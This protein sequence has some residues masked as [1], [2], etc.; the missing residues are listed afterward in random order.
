[1]ARLV[2]LQGSEPLPESLLLEGSEVVLGRQPDVG[3]RLN[4]RDVSRRHARIVVDGDRYYLEDLG[5]SNG[6]Y[7]NSARIDGRIELHEQDQ[8]RIGPYLFRFESSPSSSEQDLVIRASLPAHTSNIE[9]FRH[10]AERKLQAVLELAHVLSRSLDLDEIL[11]R[12]LDHLMHLFVQADRGLVLMLEGSN[13]VVRASKSRHSDRS[14]GPAYSRSVVRRVINEGIAI[15]AEDATSGDRINIFQTI[16]R[17]GI[18]SFMCVPLKSVHD[19][20]TIGVLQLDRFG[21]GDPFTEED[22][23]MLTAISLQL[24]VVIE[25]SVLHDELLV[26]E[27]IKRDLAIAREIQEGF[28]PQEQPQLQRGQVNLFARVYPAQEVSGDFYDFATVSDCRLAFTVADVSGKG[29]PAALF[30]TAVRTL[31]RHFITEAATPSQVLRQLNHALAAD[32]PTMMFVTMIFGFYDA[33]SGEVV[34]SNAGHP[35]AI[36][37]RAGGQ[38]EVLPQPPGRL[39]GF[40]CGEIPLAD[41]RIQLAGGDTLVLYTDG[42]TEA[43]SGGHKNMFGVDRL[44]QAVGRCQ[45]DEPLDAWG[46][47]IRTAVHEFTRSKQ[48]SDDITLLLLQRPPT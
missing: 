37:R 15:V 47:R 33:V 38:V 1:M 39:L 27:R 20:R 13:L 9:L 35:S 31:A 2:V 4:A 17:L 28:L 43:T 19:G 45:P 22:L 12:L 3:L 6:T 42:V 34:L 5:S 7:L 16:N 29:V 14:E 26:Q 41:T 36:V 8:I 18:R 24:A 10:D 21:L 30:M 44:K 11:S 23:H 46:D 32:N 48:A 40:S 25:N